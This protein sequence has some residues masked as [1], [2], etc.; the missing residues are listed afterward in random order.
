M[1]TQLSLTKTFK[2]HYEKTV[3]GTTITVSNPSY[4][5]G[6]KSDWQLT[7]DEGNEELTVNEWFPTKRECYEFCVNWLMNTTEG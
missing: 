4:V 2:G 5:T 6:E 3:E 1:T 7:I